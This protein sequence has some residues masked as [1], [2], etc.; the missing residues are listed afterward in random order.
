VQLDTPVFDLAYDGAGRLW[1][2]SGGGQLL[3]LDA[4]TLQIVGRYGDSLTQALAYD[5][6]KNLFYVSSG[7]GIETFDPET[8]AF[9]HFSNVRVDD[10][11]ISPNGTLWGTAWPKRGDVLSF[12]SRGRAQVQVRVGTG[13]D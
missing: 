4:A 9:R 7:D 11:G 6:A 8:H 10:L 3:Q 5:A 12:D 13:V 2:T 1:A